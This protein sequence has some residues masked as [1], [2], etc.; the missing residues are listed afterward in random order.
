M[1]VIRGWLLAVISYCIRLHVGESS[2]G[3]SGVAKAAR[4]TPKKKLHATS[5]HFKL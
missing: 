3:D 5:F 4:V 2:L 1:R